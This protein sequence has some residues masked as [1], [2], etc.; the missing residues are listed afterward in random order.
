MFHL[1]FLGSAEGL[2]FDVPRR[3]LRH[4]RSGRRSAPTCTGL[5]VERPRPGTRCARRLELG[6]GTGS[7]AP[8][9]T[10]TGRL[11]AD[12]VVLAPDPRGAA[13]LVAAR[14]GS[15]TTGWRDAARPWPR[16]GRRRSPSG[17][18][19]WT[20]RWHP[21]GRPFL[22]TSG[23]GPM[24]NVS[25]LERFE[26]GARRVVATRTTARSWRC[27]RTPCP[28][29]DRRGATCASGC[30]A[31][32]HR[33]YPETGATRG[34]ARGV[35]GRGRLPAGRHRA[36]AVAA[37]GAH[38]RPAARAR[39]RRG[40]L[41]LPRGADG[42]GGDHRLHGRQPAAQ[43]L[44]PARARRVVGADGLTAGPVPRLARRGIRAYRSA[45]AR[46]R[47]SDGAQQ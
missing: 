22:G 2:L 15:A 8:S 6:D 40:P 27:T 11:E 36:L 24:D 30:C 47:S 46:R 7:T 39:R 29:P 16:I 1:Y 21:T 44:G 20:G 25:V 41:R 19:G 18:C 34:R 3:R 31:E 43:R 17:G 33:V 42:A 12:T 26:A 9:A 32:L 38:P 37:R 45:A 4:A 10:T 13:R 5:G 28:R 35:A 23:Y 14:P